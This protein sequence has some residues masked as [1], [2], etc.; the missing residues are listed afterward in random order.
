MNH[1]AG[2]GQEEGDNKNESHDATQTFYKLDVQ[3]LTTH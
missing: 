1:R 3:T 2:Q